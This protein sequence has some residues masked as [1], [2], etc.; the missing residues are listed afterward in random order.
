[1]DISALLNDW[2]SLARNQPDMNLPNKESEFIRQ[3]V[4]DVNHSDGSRDLGDLV[5]FCSFSL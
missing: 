2:F 3:N 4:G 1:M 5:I